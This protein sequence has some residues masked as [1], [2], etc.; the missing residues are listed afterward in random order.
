MRIGLISDIH[1]NLPALRAVLD[2]LEDADAIL[3]AGDM[4]GYFESPNEVIAELRARGVTMIAG[5]HD[6]YLQNPPPNPNDILRRSLGSTLRAISAENLAFL[7]T[8]SCEKKLTFGGLRISM[9]HGSPWNPQEQYIYP[10]FKDWHR[11]AEIDAD[12]VLLGHTHR[13]IL[14]QIG[15][16]TLIN[17][18]SVGQPRD[19]DP[20][21]SYATLNTET[22]Q[23][24]LCRVDPV[25][26]AHSFSSGTAVEGD[27]RALK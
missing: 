15:S 13:P 26:M 16:V 27:G 7:S 23:V 17:P 25:S 24:Q 9:Y 20:R 3:C 14:R 5:N 6:V 19:G 10:D 22:R 12:V 2:A 1:A 18:G 8:L 21:P 11:F 4:T